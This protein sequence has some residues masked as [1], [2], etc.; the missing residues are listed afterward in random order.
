MTLL[1]LLRTL[2]PTIFWKPLLQLLLSFSLNKLITCWASPSI[3][4]PPKRPPSS[5]CVALAAPQQDIIIVDVA[6][7]TTPGAPQRWLPVNGILLPVV[8]SYTYL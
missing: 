2:V 8:R 5:P 3:W 4:H 7:H 1:S 6:Q